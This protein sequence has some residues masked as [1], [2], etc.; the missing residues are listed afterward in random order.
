MY[1]LFIEEK[2]YNV[3]VTALPA[4]VVNG[5][6]FHLTYGIPRSIKNGVIFVCFYEYKIII[7]KQN[8]YLYIWLYNYG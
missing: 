7:E 3:V 8:L 4:T 1:M 2:N 6:S 5:L